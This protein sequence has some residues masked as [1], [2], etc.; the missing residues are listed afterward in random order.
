MSLLVD[1]VAIITGASAGIGRATARLFAQEGAKLVL[2]ARR[3]QQLDEL[4]VEIAANG[5]EAVALAGDVADERYNKALVDV[6][7]STFGRLDIAFN[8][9]GILGKAKPVPEIDLAEWNETISTNLSSA[10]L[11]AKHQI[12]TMLDRGGSIIFTSSF[13]GYTVGFA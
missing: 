4:L 13:V 1:K 6:A 3:Q 10:F 11:A 9:A 12:P 2:A 5:G 7:I 8:N